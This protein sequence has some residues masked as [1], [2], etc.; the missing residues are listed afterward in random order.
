MSC[1]NIAQPILLWR[2]SNVIVS[3]LGST[4]GQWPQHPCLRHHLW[5][6]ETSLL[7]TVLKFEIS[8][9][10]VD[11][12]ISFAAKENSPTAV[13]TSNHSWK[14]SIWSLYIIHCINFLVPGFPLISFSKIVSSCKRFPMTACFT[15]LLRGGSCSRLSKAHQCGFS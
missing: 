9:G 8:T 3:L 14:K 2:N 6:T 13:V 15:I 12:D 4:H 10:W 5:R 1:Q 11:I 7:H